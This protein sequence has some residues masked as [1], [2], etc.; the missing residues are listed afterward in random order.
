MAILLGGLLPAL[1]HA[2][3]AAEG[4]QSFV[5]VCTV[6]GMKLVP[7]DEPRAGTAESVFLAERCAVCATHAHSAPLPPSLRPVFV[8]PREGD[9][10]PRL[11]DRPRRTLFVW[12]TASP[13]G[14]PLAPHTAAIAA[15]S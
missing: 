12:I 14:P 4:E 13:R 2:L 11:R 15:L 3:P 1:S 6:A 9:R 5:P 7:V 8:L 10:F